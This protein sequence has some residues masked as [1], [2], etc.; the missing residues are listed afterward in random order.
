MGFGAGFPAGTAGFAALAG[1][2]L[3]AGDTGAGWGAGLARVAATTGAGL[4]ACA[5]VFLGEGDVF[6]GGA[7]LTDADTVAFFLGTEAVRAA[8]GADLAGDRIT[9]F[10]SQRVHT[11][12]VRN[13]RHF[14]TTALRSL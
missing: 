9:G 5:G 14:G 2:N 12:R 13:E 7:D 4:G 10:S 8:G 3:G 1:V 11:A 6:F